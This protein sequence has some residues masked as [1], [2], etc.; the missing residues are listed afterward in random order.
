MA[1]AL[2]IE[3]YGWLTPLSWPALKHIKV[4]ARESKAGHLTIAMAQRYRGES[5][6]KVN[7]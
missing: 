3:A 7:L 6:N 2:D 1:Q 5:Q 4:Q